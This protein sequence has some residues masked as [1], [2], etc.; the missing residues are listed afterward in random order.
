MPKKVPKKIEI[1]LIPYKEKALYEARIEYLEDE[2]K[3][4]DMR[5]FTDIHHRV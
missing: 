4:K 2:Y 1:Y 5:Y 3:G